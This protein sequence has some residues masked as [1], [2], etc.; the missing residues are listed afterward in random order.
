MTNKVFVNKRFERVSSGFV[1]KKFILRSDSELYHFTR[2][3]TSDIILESQ[4]LR[5][6]KFDLSNDNK[7]FSL[8]LSIVSD[9]L[10]EF[11]QRNDY[12]R[13]HFEKFMNYFGEEVHKPQMIFHMV[14]FCRRKNNRYLHKHY[15]E[16]GK[17][18]CLRFVLC[19]E[20]K[21]NYLL[22]EVIYSE[23]T[24][25]RR[26]LKTIYK[27]YSYLKN[28][29]AEI[30][31]NHEHAGEFFILLLRDLMVLSATY[32]RNRFASEREVRMLSFSKDLDQEYDFFKLAG[33]IVDLVDF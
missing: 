2:A 18:N 14:C 27:Y 1:V 30:Y 4:Q 8:G 20:N 15:A 5:L 29:E 23:R 10:A 13:K 9:V 16:N 6:T 28:N 7:E 3:S 25:K 21:T 12:T 19:K 22:Y 32:K 26:A 17:G 31:K 24:L 33:S 11:V